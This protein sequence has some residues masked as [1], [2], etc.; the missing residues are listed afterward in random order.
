MLGPWIWSILPPD[1]F[2][3][4]MYTYASTYIDICM[5]IYTVQLYIFIY[6]YMKSFC[7]YTDKM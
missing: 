3:R 7:T 4:Y 1:V 2:E 5:C 6:I